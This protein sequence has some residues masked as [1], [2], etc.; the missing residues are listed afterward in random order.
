MKPKRSPKTVN[1]P[2]RT[3]HVR[4]ELTHPNAREVCLA[5]T[6]NAWHPAATPMVALGDGRWVKELTLTPGRYEYRFVADGEWLADPGAAEVAENGFGGLN[7]V[8]VVPP[9]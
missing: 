7:S 3:P 5:G 9:N 8:L 2:P 4:L 1:H 6:F